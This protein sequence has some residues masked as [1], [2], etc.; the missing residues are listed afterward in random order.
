MGWDFSG[1]DSA[2]STLSK[3]AGSA[4]SAIGKADNALRKVDKLAGTASKA[5]GGSSTSTQGGSSDGVTYQSAGGGMQVTSSGEIVTPPDTCIVIPAATSSSG[6]TRYLGKTPYDSIMA[7]LTGEGDCRN[8]FIK[9]AYGNPSSKYYAQTAD[10]KLVNKA[11]GKPIEFN[12]TDNGEINAVGLTEQEMD[13]IE[14]GLSN[15]NKY[16]LSQTAQGEAENAEN[17]SWLE[18]NWAWLTSAIVAV[19]GIG[20]TFFMARKYK[21]EQKNAKS[22][23]AALSSQVTDLQGKLDALKKDNAGNNGSTNTDST[24]TNNTLADNSVRVVGVSNSVVG[25]DA[26]QRSNS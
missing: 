1:L 23:S 11:T 25:T 19:I 18:R 10:G 5:L 12:K 15:K 3:S 26:Y 24:N 14:R 4:S 6:I 16:K 20:I 8:V 9:D 2:M 21:K 17:R 22:E 13:A 7:L